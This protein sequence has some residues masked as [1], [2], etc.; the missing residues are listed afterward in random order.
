MGWRDK[1]ASVKRSFCRALFAVAAAGLLCAGTPAWAF[2]STS[3]F[4][5]TFGNSWQYNAFSGGTVNAGAISGTPAGTLSVAVPVMPTV[6]INGADTRQVNF[7]SS[8]SSY[9]QFFSN[10][11]NGIRQHRE[12][13]FNVATNITSPST[14]TA[15]LTLDSAIPFALLN[16]TLGQQTGSSGV[17][18][19]VYDAIPQ[20]GSLSF[21]VNYS[22]SSTIQSFQTVTVPAGTFDTA[23]VVQTLTISG[24]AAN[25]S[26]NGTPVT[27]TPPL[28]INQS[29]T[30]TVWVASNVGLVQELDDDGTAMVLA[31]YAVPALTPSVGNLQ[32][33]RQPLNAPSLPQLVTL[34]NS[35][36]VGLNSPFIG[37]TDFQGQGQFGLDSSDCP[38]TMA[39]GAQCTIGI[40]YTPKLLGPNSGVANIFFNNDLAFPYQVV[41]LAG[42]NART[43]RDDFGS[44][45]K[46]DVFWLNTDTTQTY[47]WQM[48]GASIASSGSPTSTGDPNWQVA[49]I[50]DF[51]ADGKADVLFRHAVTGATV[52]WLMN[53]TAIAN[54][55][56]PGTVADLDWQVQGIGDFD[57]DGRA[58]ILWVHADGSVRIWL[59]NGTVIASSGSP[60]SLGASSGWSVQGI[61]D[62]DG[63]RRADILWRHASGTVV[64]WRM[65]GPTIVSSAVVA[66]VGDA[67]AGW[68]V[69]GVGD[70]DGDGKADVLWRNDVLGG[71][72]YVWLMDGPAIVSSA[73]VAGVG[74]RRA[75]VGGAGEW[76]TTTGTA[77]RT[78]SGRTTRCWGAS[79]TCG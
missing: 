69:Q 76:G 66:G 4:P 49:G 43:R 70:F 6:T 78:C 5:L 3:Y 2:R 46:S 9:Q 72:V 57:G 23:V 52:I 26:C 19:F 42:T 8:S 65:N 14:G 59:M 34:T 44:D 10:D 75:G 31:S 79:P 37:V 29:S 40:I 33:D 77:R 15:T 36:T 39:A 1:G 58:D 27:L 30:Q 64:A 67:S 22:A 16:A 48:N 73:V 54:A 12:I 71:I 62:F 51:D 32:F 20:C 56:S 47:V 25:V 24:T 68:V 55:G 17:A 41:N 50:G 13:D 74:T 53:G 28:S 11:S 61:G 45:G 63:D 18:T 7:T 35:G 38:S 21:Q 60:A